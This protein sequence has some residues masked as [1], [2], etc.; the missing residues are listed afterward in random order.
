[1]K[2]LVPML[3]IIFAAAIAHADQTT[4]LLK[5]TRVRDFITISTAPGANGTTILQYSTDSFANAGPKTL[6]TGTTFRTAG[7]VSIYLHDFNPLTQTYSVSAKATPDLS[8][9]AIKGF[10]D[11]LKALAPSLGTPPVAPPQPPGPPVGGS[12]PDACDELRTLIR[13]AHTALVAV[14]LSASDLEAIVNG[15]AGYTG[16]RKAA[17]D[18][19]AAQERIAANIK[20]ARDRIKTIRTDFGSFGGAAPKKSCPAIGS[21][22]L[23]DYIEVQSTADQIIATKSALNKQLGELVKSLKPYLDVRSWRGASSAAL[24]DYAITRVTPTF[25]DQ[26]SVSVEAK[27]RNV[28]IVDNALTIT[29]DETTKATAE[30]SVRRDSFFVPERAAAMV[31][32]SLTYPQYGTAKNPAGETIV[33]RTDDHK[34][35]DAAMMLN[36]VMRLRDGESVAQPLLQL[37]VSSAKDFPGLLA[38]VGIRF[39]EPFNFSLSVGGLITRYK[40]LDDDLKEGQ[41][42][43][44]TA[45]INEHLVL[46]TSPVAIYGAIQLKF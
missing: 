37:G 15:A 27:V 7:E 40:D 30:F 19:T 36:L 10:F 9:G 16:V 23:V 34:P 11:D 5:A 22:I 29:T 44:G 39:V 1:M 32:N 35:I 25:V 8:Y 31:Y 2:R 33:A 41:V 17:A 13:E 43:S 45:E 21:D 6:A 42:V 24:T 46:K 14:E 4:D 18:L 20:I 38:G 26:Q 28:Q 12:G 3:L